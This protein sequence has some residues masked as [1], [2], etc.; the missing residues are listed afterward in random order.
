MPKVV[1]AGKDKTDEMLSYAQECLP[2]LSETKLLSLEEPCQSPLELNKATSESHFL[3]LFINMLKSRTGL[4]RLATAPIRK[5]WNLL[6]NYFHFKEMGLQ[7][8]LL[9]QQQTHLNEAFQHALQIQREE[10]ENRISELERQLKIQE[11]DKS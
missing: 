10:F 3:K 9:I 8:E 6:G 2:E 4:T 11:D 7:T 1:I 5:P